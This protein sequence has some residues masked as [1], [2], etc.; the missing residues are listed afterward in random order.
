MI[1]FNA[2][3]GGDHISWPMVELST[4]YPYIEGVVQ[5]ALDEFKPIDVS[6]LKHR[7]SGLY[8]VAKQT[9]YLKPIFDVCEQYSWCWK[10]HKV[11]DTL[12]ELTH[13]DLE[14]MNYFIYSS[15]EGNPV[16]KLLEQ[17]NKN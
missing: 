3:P 11:S 5:I 8:Y 10:K 9:S 13:N 7:Y 17:K 16:A 6:S 15:D 1:E 12:E 14:N 4:G 2:R